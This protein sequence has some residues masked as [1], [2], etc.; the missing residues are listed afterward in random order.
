[1]RVV[2]VRIPRSGGITMKVNR[3][4]CLE[5]V[6]VTA[7]GD[8][9]C[10]HAG[11]LLLVN[12][13]DR[14]GLTAGLSKA[15]AGTRRRRSVHDD[16]EILRDLIVTLVAGGEHL[17]DLAALRDQPDL[18]GNVAS[19]STAFRLIERIGPSQLEG[20][21]VARKMARERAFALGARPE[22]LILDVDAT[23]VGSHSDKEHARGNYKGGYGFH[24]MLCYLDGSDGALDGILR[25]GNAGSNT[26]ADQTQAVELALQQLPEGCMTE[27]LLVRGDTAACVHELIDFCRDAQMRFSVGHDLNSE[28]REAIAKL[29]EN[30]WIPAISQDGKPVTDH[31]TR[32]RKAYVAEL[33]S[34]MGLSGWGPGA[35]L[36]VRRERAH[37]GA[38]LSLIDTDGWR[39]Q[40]FLTDQDDDDLAE[41]DR[42]HRAHA[43]VEARI[44]DS[45]ALGLS[46]LPFR[47]YEMNE[48]WMQLALCAQDL[49]A[50]AKALTL[51]DDLARAKP[52]TLRYRLLHQAGRLARSGRHTK[53][54]LARH[55]PWAED[56]LT[57]CTRLD[58]LPIPAG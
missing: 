58:A 6:E 29:P 5:T 44:E 54:R 3:R 9:F 45:H 50:Y 35:R 52:H 21:R 48:T 33:T 53:L 20:L 27:D 36:L 17:S 19:D 43:H 30:A 18:F 12:L 10:S 57:A 11:A 23:L 15:L 22:K 46:K 13:A 56:L 32:P 16:G 55:W 31:P 14:L 51:T 34:L 42:S 28:V 1:M 2:E 41:L 39:H 47:A 25:P 26:G 49:L 7:D 4:G 37:P 40:A 24:P 8:G 38:Q